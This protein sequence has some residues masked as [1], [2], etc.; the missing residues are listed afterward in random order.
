MLGAAAVAAC[1]EDSISGPGG[2]ACG[3]PPYFT[4]LPVPEADLSSVSVFG[5]LD[6]PGHVLPTPHGGI[7]LAREDVPLAAPGDMTVT[8]L[9]RVRYEGP[10]VPPGQEDYAIF[11]QAC[12]EVSGWFGHVSAL[13]PRLSGSTIEFRDC[14]TYSVPWATVESC[15]AR[16]VD[17]AI[18]AGDDLGAG[19]PVMDFGVLDERVTNFYVSPHRFPSST[20]HAVCMWEQFDAANQAIFFSRLRDIV[21]PGIA[22]AGEP[23]CGTMSVDV[24]GRAKGVWALPGTG[25]VAGDERRYIAL[26]D[27]PYRPELELALSLGP[28]ELGARLA[29]V[30]RQSSGRVNRPFQEVGPDGLVYCYGPPVNGSLLSS[31]FLQ[32]MGTAQLRI[33]RVAHGLGLSPC[34]GDPAAWTFGPDAITMER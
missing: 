11:F 32:A 28:E 33:E 22:P 1:G 10:D 6:A 29:V 8:T 26:A 30:T 3:S 25:L 23:R 12:R 31:W 19:G 27:Y 21:R 5:G 14:E 16:D 15:E 18:L 13:A 9:R 34:G 20:F 7:F 24:A 2:E 17:L 4:V